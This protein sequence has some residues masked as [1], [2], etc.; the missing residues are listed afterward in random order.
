MMLKTARQDNAHREFRKLGK[1]K[2]VALR[3]LGY[4]AICG[5]VTFQFTSP[6]GT[7][8]KYSDPW[9]PSCQVSFSF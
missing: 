7:D 5:C 6:T 8:F 4:A 9:N 2:Q 3:T 1:L